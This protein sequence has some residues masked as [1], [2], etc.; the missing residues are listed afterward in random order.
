MN[1]SLN[2][3]EVAFRN[4]VRAFLLGLPEGL[5]IRATF[6]YEYPRETR[7]RFT[8][9][10][11]ARGWLVPHWT[12][13]WGGQNW[14]PIR[15]YI[16]AEE[17][18]RHGC[19]EIERIGTDLVGPTLLA[20]GT[21]AQRDR[22]LPGILDGS[23][24][25]CQGFSEA[26]AGS[27]LS[28]V[29]T[30]ARREGQAYRVNGHKL[31]TTQAHEAQRMFALVKVDA[32]RGVQPGL[33]FVLIDM[34]AAGVTVLP[35]ITIDGGH[36][37]NEVMLRDVSVP[38]EDRVG[39]EGKGWTYARALLGTERA[40]AAGIPH[41]RRDLAHLRDFARRE[42]R[43]ERPLWNDRHFRARYAELDAEVTAL[44][45][46][47]LRLLAAPASPERDAL[48]SVLK[49][50]GA[51]AYQRV[52]ELMLEVT[53][54]LADDGDELDTSEWRRAVAAAY[55]FRRSAT[56]AGGTSEVQRN[57][58]AAITLHL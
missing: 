10:L 56:I 37:I 47:L 21:S 52:S 50:R 58:I 51:L 57:L 53:C 6:G 26:E 23:E 12:T 31:W 14:P 20:F 49:L 4:D 3:E 13:E 29:R 27:D 2:D 18:C 9:A 36:H 8:R 24:F 39:E 22:Y 16:L 40:G 54:L 19:P 15:H 1:L 45:F 7:V 30:I 55:L 41:T 5:G 35:I 25:W 38:V 17:L 32:G 11:A 34:R 28:G 48:A 44:E 46:L 42:R 43:R 33:T